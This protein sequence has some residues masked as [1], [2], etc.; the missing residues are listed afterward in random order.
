[1][2][3]WVGRRRLWYKACVLI[4]VSFAVSFS[5][6][7]SSFLFLS[8]ST[9][10]L[11]LPP[12]FNLFLSHSFFVQRPIIVSHTGVV[13]TCNNSRN[14]LDK[15]IER[16]A[17]SGGM[18]SIA[19]FDQAVCGTSIEHIVNAIKHVRDLVGI[20]YVGLGSDF[21]GTVAVGFDTSKLN[22]I[23]SYLLNDASFTKED[24]RKVM[25]GNAI[26]LL[27]LLLPDK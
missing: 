9:F 7:F 15:H 26:R 3:W 22:Y 4:V 11:S 25:G 1:V 18:V 6:S 27:K 5:F 8:L 23:T 21:D 14:L 24:I 12:S 13:G 17:L 2:W 19:Y 16:I 20:E 10:S